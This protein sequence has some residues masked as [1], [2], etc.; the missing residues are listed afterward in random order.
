MLLLRFHEFFFFKSNSNSK[1]IFL[2]FFSWKVLRNDNFYLK[3]NSTFLRVK[4][5]YWIIFLN[6]INY[7][8]F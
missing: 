6:E 2:I 7:I 3:H 1:N 4:K 5:Y 8:F